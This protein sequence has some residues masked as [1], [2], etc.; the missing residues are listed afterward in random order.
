MYF[1]FPF[2]P[3][4]I[5]LSGVLC[6]C[7]G[8]G[9]WLTVMGGL[10]RDDLSENQSAGV[11]GTMADAEDIPVLVIDAG[12]GG[13]DGGARAADG[14]E[15]KAINLAIA[16]MLAEIAA[17]YPVE[18]VMT[19]TS[20]DGLYSPQNRDSRKREDL[21]KRKEIMAD[22]DPVVAVSIHLNSYPQDVFV[23]GPQ[24]FYSPDPVQGD[25]PRTDEQ[26][27]EQERPGSRD[28]A[29]SVQK[30]L[31]L[32]IPDGRQR[33]PMAKNDVLLLKDP[34]CP[35]ILAECGFLSN[36]AETDKLKTAE[37]QGLLAE[38]I[39]SGINEILCLEK[40]ERVPV[41]DSANRGV[42]M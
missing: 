16:Q 17:D 32:H 10:G 36:S 11:S 19:R 33:T 35:V 38:A 41:V 5:F 8:A 26:T 29:E 30:A 21:L 25:G 4:K 9:A 18:V 40:R 42:E 27:G 39:W 28:F 3:R 22:S 20:D 24:V 34:P 7:L 23:Y 15:E 6:F 14:T 31:E 37:Y 12:H 2:L 1:K 13:F